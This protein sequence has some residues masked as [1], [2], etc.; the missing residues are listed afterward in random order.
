MRRMHNR[1]L[2][3]TLAGLLLIV[4]GCAELEERTIVLQPVQAAGVHHTT[5]S[6]FGICHSRLEDRAVA[7]LL[8]YLFATRMDPLMYGITGYEV[9]IARG[10][11]CHLR[12]VHQFQTAVRFDF[13]S[14]PAGAIARATLNFRA[15]VD[16]GTDPSILPG[17]YDQ[18]RISSVLRATEAWDPP[19]VPPYQWDGMLR[20]LIDGEPLR[21]ASAP[22]GWGTPF[23]P[24]D[25]TRTVVAWVRGEMPNNGFI[26]APD[27]NQIAQVAGTIDDLNEQMMCGVTLGDARLEISMLVPRSP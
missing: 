23:H 22:L 2:A 12:V 3:G 19:S 1:L 21:P 15:R 7:S 20:G 9:R 17:T 25:V 10:E 4:S 16:Y 26:V 8:R 18:C 11:S 24:Q 6:N 27:R 13:S 14:L 5:Y